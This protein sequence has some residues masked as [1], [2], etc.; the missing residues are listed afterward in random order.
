MEEILQGHRERYL[1]VCHMELNVFQNFCEILR[2]RHLLN[3]T[4]GVKVE[5]QLAMFLYILGK[6]SINRTVQDRFQYSG[7]TVSR[8]F[9]RVLN[10]IY[11]LSF[12]YVYLPSSNTP[13]EIRKKCMYYPFFKNC[14]GVID[15]TH[16]H[17][18]IGVEEW[19]G[20][21]SDSS[22]LK[23]TLKSGFKVPKGGDDWLYK[24]YDRD[25]ARGSVEGTNIQHTDVN[26]Q[27]DKNDGDELRDHIA[28]TL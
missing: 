3:D 1:Q 10:A 2:S 12:D 15:G 8:H 22:A 16:I 23:A 19:E 18:S 28:K 13:P 7:E 26:H 25:L 11:K 4:R 5:E 9:E 17:V 24:E 27:A 20:S 6:S 21:S 14:I